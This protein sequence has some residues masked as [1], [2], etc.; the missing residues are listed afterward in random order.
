MVV[1][2]YSLPLQK[3]PKYQGF[4]GAVFGLSSVLGPTVGGVFTTDVSWRWCFYINRKFPFYCAKGSRRFGLIGVLSS[5][6]WRFGYGSCLLLASYSET[7]QRQG[8]C[9][10]EAVAA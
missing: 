9:E 1:M 10:G 3:R 6:Y 4:F 2:V 7:D 8:R 5:A